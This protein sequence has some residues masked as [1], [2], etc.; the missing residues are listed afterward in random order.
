MLSLLRP[1]RLHLIP[2]MA[3]KSLTPRHLQEKRVYLN[4]SR[5]QDKDV[6]VLYKSREKWFNILVS[7]GL[8]GMV[9]F[10]INNYYE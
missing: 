1:H 5:F 3:M 8:I 10:N 2:R 7:L 6:L 4:I 9:G